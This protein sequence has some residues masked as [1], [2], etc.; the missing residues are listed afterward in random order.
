[1]SLVKEMAQEFNTSSLEQIAHAAETF[2]DLVRYQHESRSAAWKFQQLANA[3]RAVLKM[4]ND[5]ENDEQ[6]LVRL[7]CSNKLSMPVD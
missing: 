1:M 6:V 3:C 4:Q 7:V 2:A 5:D